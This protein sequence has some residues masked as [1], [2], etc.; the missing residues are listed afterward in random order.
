M[1]SW[2]V[3]SLFRASKHVSKERRTGSPQPALT[4]GCCAA[5]EARKKRKRFL[6]SQLT[7]RR[8][9]CRRCR[10]R[11]HLRALFCWFV[12][13]LNFDACGTND[14]RRFYRRL[15]TVKTRDDSGVGRRRRERKKKH[16]ATSSIDV[17]FFLPFAIK[18]LHVGQRQTAFAITRRAFR[19]EAL[20]W[21]LGVGLAV[22]EG[23]LLVHFFS[24]FA[25][26]KKKKSRGCEGGKKNSPF[27]FDLDRPSTRE[28]E[29]ERG[30]KKKLRSALLAVQRKVLL[31]ARARAPSDQRS[32]GS[33]ERQAH[34][35]GK[36][37]PSAL[38]SR[39][40]RKTRERTPSKGGRGS[41]KKRSKTV[42]EREPGAAWRLPA[43]REH[44]TRRAVAST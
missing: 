34:E 27:V 43:R 30:E 1:L 22:V 6:F 24:S 36:L 18:C 4:R 16:G 37:S 40:R 39:R 35:H 42:K 13:C 28:R 15:W 41:E 21:L 14:E 11:R 17:D 12:F 31:F 32:R 29:R 3:P 7:P 44:A 9:P 26:K 25:L 5:T 10:Q 20:T 19:H 33:A 23:V 38:S 2:H 8:R